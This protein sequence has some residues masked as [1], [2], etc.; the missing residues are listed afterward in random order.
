METKALQTLGRWVAELPGARIPDATLRAARFQ[1][2]NMI[3]AARASSRLHDTQGI[4]RAAQAWSGGSGRATVVRSGTKTDPLSAAWINAAGAMAQDFDDILWMG[5]TC[6][7]AVFASL[8]LAEHLGSTAKEFLEAVVVANEVSGRLGASCFLGPLNGQMVTHIHLIG[9]AAAG[10]R[11][12]KLDATRAAHALAISLS[13]PGFALQ[14]AFMLPSSKLLSA[15]TPTVVGM[16]AAFAA[17]EGITGEL[18]LLEDP[19]G[20]WKRFSFIPFPQMMADLG[21]FWALQT[22]SIKTFPGCQYFQTACSALEA[23]ARKRGPID[24][25]TVEAVDVQT[26]K[27]GM[28]VNRFGAEYGARSEVLTEVNLN[29]DLATT[30]AVHLAAGRL[31]SEQADAEWLAAN[32]SRV[33]VLRERVTVQ[34]DPELTLKV[35]ASGRALPAGRKA[36]SQLTPGNLLELRRRYSQEYRSSLFPARELGRWIATAAKKVGSRT[37]PSTAVTEAAASAIPLYFPN[38]V[39]LR[40]K[41]GTRETAQVDL[42]VGAFCAPGAE[43]ELRKKFVSATGSPEAFELGLR[44]GSGSETTA[45]LG[46]LDL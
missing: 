21:D 37:P 11:L 7:S 30:L 14:P 13:Q 15:A 18:G 26:T 28:E 32:T 31:T 20:F 27:L 43:A 16:Q 44:L 6:H 22:L 19:R 3:A 5:H 45:F 1:V 40:F 23:I 2:L 17:K 39:T 8:A 34:H 41:D 25:E 10:A 29:F 42:P 46:A 36:L 38:R 9:A 12:L 35:L 4:E 24:P 33:R